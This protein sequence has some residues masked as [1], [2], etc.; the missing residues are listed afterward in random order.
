MYAYGRYIKIFD[1]HSKTTHTM[2]K[3]TQKCFMELYEEIILLCAHDTIKICN[4]D[5]AAC[6]V[7]NDNEQIGYMCLRG[8]FKLGHKIEKKS[9]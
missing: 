3:V 4:P 7:S 6:N 1:V 8:N 9:D 2:P 5:C